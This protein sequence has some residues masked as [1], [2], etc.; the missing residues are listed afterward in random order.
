[1]WTKKGGRT[2][3]C[4]VISCCLSLTVIFRCRLPCNSATIQFTDVAANDWFRVRRSFTRPPP[5]SCLPSPVSHPC[6]VNAHGQGE[7]EDRTPFLQR[8]SLRGTE[9]IRSRR[10]KQKQASRKAEKENFATR[11][12]FQIRQRRRHSAQHD[13]R[14]EQSNTEKG[15]NTKLDAAGIFH[16]FF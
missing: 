15:G 11:S 2:R 3:P 7:Y 5:V 4:R 9:C 14:T 13:I 16:L 1:M 12:D 10:E 6:D 8:N